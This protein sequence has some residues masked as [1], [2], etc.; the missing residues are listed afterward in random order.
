M[1]LKLSIT[2]QN[3]KMGAIP[4]L[5]VL[6]KA[7]QVASP[8]PPNLAATPLDT[9]RRTAPIHEVQMRHIITITK[10]KRMEEKPM[11]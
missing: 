8:Q 10:M 3:L 2:H 1:P 7:P 4:L 6:W 9:A 11:K 5:D